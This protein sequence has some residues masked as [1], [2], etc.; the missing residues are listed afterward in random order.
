M[1]VGAHHIV[2]G[3]F[4]ASS[5]RSSPA[6]HPQ[7]WGRGVGLGRWV[8]T[9]FS[10]P[11]NLGLVRC[12]VSSGRL[13]VF[14]W[15]G[16]RRVCGRPRGI[17]DPWGLPWVRVVIDSV[18]K[19]K[20]M[21]CLLLDFCAVLME[22]GAKHHFLNQMSHA[23]GRYAIFCTKWNFCLQFQGQ[24]SCLWFNHCAGNLDCSTKSALLVV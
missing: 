21:T 2:L 6:C 10:T 13:P 18:K 20:L 9:G 16:R 5:G 8:G 7:G 22:H 17:N 15:V 4:N 12:H 14:C 3:A 24:I 23:V 11:L 19:I 1:S